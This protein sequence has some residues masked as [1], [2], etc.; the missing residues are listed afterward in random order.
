MRGPYKLTWYGCDLATGAIAEELPALSPTQALSRRLGAPT[1]TAFSLALAGAPREW[2]SATD[3][4]RTMLVGVDSQSGTPVWC[5]LI[6]TRDGGSSNTLDLGVGTPEGYLD[7]RY[8][9]AY[10][11]S[12]ADASTVIADLAAPLAATGLPITFDTTA[13]GLLIDYTSVDTDDKGILSSVSTISAMA[14]APEWTI[15][16]VWADANQTA[17]ELVMRIQPT[18][19]TVDT[20]PESVFDLPGCID[21]YR[22]IESYEQGKG[23]TVVV[24]SGEGEGGA[25]IQSDVQTANDLIT[26][27]WIRWIHRYTPGTAITSVEQ[28]N[29]HAQATLALLRTGSKA[30]K[31]GAVA[32]AAPR[33]GTDWGLGDSVSVQVARSPRHPA[34]ASTVARAYGWDLDLAGDLVTPYLLED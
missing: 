4:G 13:S 16:P 5:G 29:A 34:G 9:G 33:L 25:R 19:G 17:F 11:A 18:I 32:S 27:G 6:L 23:A 30:W 20:A 22:L 2:E 3:P 7:R 26:A 31:V 14:G 8:P 1:S 24:A 28:L 21:S 12:Q 15:D 10:T